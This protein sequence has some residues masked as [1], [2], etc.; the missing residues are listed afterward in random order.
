MCQPQGHGPSQQPGHTDFLSLATVSLKSTFWAQRFSQL[1]HSVT[2]SQ[3][4]RHN[5]T[6][7]QKLRHNT[8]SVAAKCYVTMSFVQQ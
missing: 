2:V 8:K 3:Q 4:P 5:V 7:G 1:S 6:V